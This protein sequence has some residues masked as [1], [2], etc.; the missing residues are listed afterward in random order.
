H[1]N[2][3]ARKLY[4]HSIRL[5]SSYAGQPDPLASSGRCRIAACRLA[6]Q[7]P[8]ITRQD[9]PM[10]APQPSLSTRA[11][12]IIRTQLAAISPR[13]KHTPGIHTRATGFLPFASPARD[14]VAVAF[15]EA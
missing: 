15:R 12:W 10:P 8:R 11:R 1:R 13:R 5:A 14:V 4:A 9:A 2:A 7:G 6:A 3:H